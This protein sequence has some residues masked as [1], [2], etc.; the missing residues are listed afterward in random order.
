MGFNHGIL[1]IYQLVQDF[2]AIHMKNHS[3]DTMGPQ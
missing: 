1:P 3:I 2:A